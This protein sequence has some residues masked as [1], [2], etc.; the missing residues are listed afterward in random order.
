MWGLPTVVTSAI[1]G[2]GILVYWF[3]LDFCGEF[4]PLAVVTSATA[5][6]GILVCSVALV[7]C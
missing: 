1:A 6:G 5:G 3:P 2:R 4:W 7:F